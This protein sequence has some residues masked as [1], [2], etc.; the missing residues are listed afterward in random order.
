[1]KNLAPDSIIAEKWF[2]LFESA[3]SSFDFSFQ[4]FVADGLGFRFAKF[5]TNTQKAAKLRFKSLQC[6]NRFE[7]LQ[8]NFAG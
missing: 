3:E 2:E 1:M 7:F 6:Q 5:R 8:V 4:G